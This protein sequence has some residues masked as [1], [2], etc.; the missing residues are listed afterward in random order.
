[1]TLD[2]ARILGVA[3]RVGSIEVGKEADLALFDRHPFNV[4]GKNVMTWIDGALVYDRAVEG[5]PDGRR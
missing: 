3:D 4:Y 2:A 1:V 5:V